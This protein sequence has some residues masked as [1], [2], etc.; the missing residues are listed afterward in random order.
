[1]LEGEEPARP[2]KRRAIQGDE[3]SPEIGFARQ[4]H[5]GAWPNDQH[6]NYQ[7]PSMSSSRHPQFYNYSQSQEFDEEDEEESMVS[8]FGEPVGFPRRSRPA[9]RPS[10]NQ[11]GPDRNPS[12]YSG[13]VNTYN[14]NQ[15][16]P[17]VAQSEVSDAYLK[18]RGLERGKKSKVCK[19][20][21]GANDPENIRI[22][23]M[24]ETDG[25]TMA[26]IAKVLNVD[27][28]AMGRKPTLT[29][30][31][32]SAR[33]A[34]TA[35]LLFAAQG[36]VFVPLSERRKPGW[37]KSAPK[38]VWT[39]ELDNV[40]VGCVQAWEQR[41]WTDVADLFYQETGTRLDPEIVSIR[42]SML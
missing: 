6:Q 12:R 30:L 2:T 41:R 33:Y 34:R 18:K 31:S 3:G 13:V 17:M 1:M 26:E 36:E 24:H 14:V 42:Y 5:P 7:G 25:M 20:G 22:V 15:D 38:I 23:N 37:E 19:R 28:V 11:P 29:K 9:P 27:R 32:C 40:L 8:N 16:P 4:Q 21:Y 35:P 10:F 39:E